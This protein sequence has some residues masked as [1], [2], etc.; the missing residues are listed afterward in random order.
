[1]RAA[2]TVLKPREEV[3]TL[4]TSTHRPEYIAQIDASVSFRELYDS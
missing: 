3:Q 1:M 2:I 4:W